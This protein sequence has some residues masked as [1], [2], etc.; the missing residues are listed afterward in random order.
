[1]KLLKGLVHS[2]IADSL[3]ASSLK[4]QVEVALRALL[5]SSR[6]WLLKWIM[7]LIMSQSVF[8][9]AHLLLEVVNSSGLEVA[10][11][12]YDVDED[13]GSGFFLIVVGGLLMQAEDDFD[14]RLQFFEVDGVGNGVSVIKRTVADFSGV[15]IF[16]KL[17]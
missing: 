7:Q 8:F 17:Y 3:G 13:N 15:I 14:F 12:I 16:L 10:F 4:G 9:C 11:Q 6:E 1:M 2:Y 5:I